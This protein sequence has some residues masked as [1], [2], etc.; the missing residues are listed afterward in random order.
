MSL[1]CAEMDLSRTFEYGMGYVALSRVR[2]LAGIKLLGL[3]KMALKIDKLM[4]KSDTQLIKR[5]Q[6]DLASFKK[7]KAKERLKLQQDF[8]QTPKES[9]LFS[10][11][12]L[13]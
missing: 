7:I 11:P 13:V 1:D 5:S 10:E 12:S 3:N 2:S 4:I 9:G 8:L 6:A